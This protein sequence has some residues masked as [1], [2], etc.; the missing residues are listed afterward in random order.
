MSSV[1]EKMIEPGLK[2][3]PVLDVIHLETHG[4]VTFSIAQT[5]NRNVFTEFDRKLSDHLAATTG[6][7]FPSYK[8]TVRITDSLSK[9]E[10]QFLETTYYDSMP[11]ALLAIAERAVA[12]AGPVALTLLR[13]DCKA[14]KRL[15]VQCRRGVDRAFIKTFEGALGICNYFGATAFLDLSGEFDVVKI[16]PPG[17]L[18]PVVLRLQDDIVEIPSMQ[19]RG[20][21]PF[22]WEISAFAENASNCL[23]AQRYAESVRH[24][25]VTEKE[26]AILAFRSAA[27]QQIN[28]FH[29]ALDGRPLEGHWLKSA[30][31]L[32]ARLRAGLGNTLAG[33]SEGA[34]GQAQDWCAEIL[35]AWEANAAAASAMNSSAEAPRATNRGEAPRATNGS[36]EA[37]RVTNGSGESPRV[38]NDNEQPLMLWSAHNGRSGAT[39]AM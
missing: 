30:T 6:T 36:G 1:F 2:C 8:V 35:K 37:P 17:G 11:H 32:I 22:E 29:S 23:S 5:V 10:P 4:G 3:I 38:T 39:R 19:G 20:V 21:G 28:E 14:E 7:G 26:A 31:A 24:A 16:T 12:W 15:P 18:D 33:I 34:R 27:E 9:N 25:I 13:A